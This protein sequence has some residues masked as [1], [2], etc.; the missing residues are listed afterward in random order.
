MTKRGAVPTVETALAM[1]RQAFAVKLL[2][3]FVRYPLPDRTVRA[4]PYNYC[5]VPRLLSS[6]LPQSRSA[7]AVAEAVRRALALACGD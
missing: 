2:D 5:A 1:D 7:Q 4:V 6:L 3:T